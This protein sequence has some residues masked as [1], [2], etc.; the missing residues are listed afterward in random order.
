MEEDKIIAM[1]CI[2]Y[3]VLPPNDWCPFGKTAYVGNLYT[4]PQYR[5]NGI[6]KEILTRLVEDAKERSCERMLI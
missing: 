1:G 3:F 4:I 5:R 6:A 2:N